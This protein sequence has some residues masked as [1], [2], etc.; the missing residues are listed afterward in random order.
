M[1][2][3]SF[4]T[5][6]MV[7]T[8]IGVV[9]SIGIGKDQFW[10]GLFGSVTGFNPITLFETT[11]LKVHIAG[12][13]SG[14][15]PKSIL[16]PAGLTDLDRATL[17]I[18][19]AAKLGIDD[20]KINID[21]SN[22]KRTGIS[23]GT[24]FGSLHSI[25]KFDRESLTEGPA[26]VNPS[27]FP[28]TVGNSPASRVAIRFKV[29]GFN[30]TLSTGMCSAID[31]ID[32]ARDSL[33]LDRADTVLCGAVEDLSL[34]TFLGFY[35]LNYLSGSK[36][37]T[38]I[39]SCP[40][41]KRRNG[42]IFSEGATALVVQD[43]NM[44]L[45]TKAKIYAEILGIG[46]CFDPARFYNYSPKGEGMRHAM[47]MA[48]QDAGLLPEDIDCIFANANSTP[49]A[50]LIETHAIKSVFGKYAKKIPVT[51]V[52]SIVGE[53]YSVSG[54][55]STVAALGAL[56]NQLVPRISNY[57]EKDPDCDLNYVVNK[58]EKKKLSRIMINAFSP[59]GGN[60]SFI[61]GKATRI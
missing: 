10:Q 32:Y 31:A 34:Q 51:A 58:P 19:C 6:R 52:K 55:F 26:Y 11:D 20:A 4:K 37:D 44:A 49:D 38:P 48:L 56:E 35:R 40:F 36:N 46:S 21:E 33:L 16:G 24:T 14:F 18:L 17:L 60:I 3:T 5:R 43:K 23:V 7:V 59:S 50:D 27:I 47:Q 57:K 9:S 2:K 41:D 61:I 30:S 28:S 39:M 25:S 8:G 15:D 54:G 42:I 12:E 22:T 29:K 13:I 53:G 1:I 45:N